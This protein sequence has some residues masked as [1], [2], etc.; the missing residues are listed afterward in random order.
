MLLTLGFSPCPNDTFIFDALVHEKVDTEGLEFEP[1]LEDVEALNL[2]AFRGE[3]AVTKLSYAAFGHVLPKYAMLTAGSALGFGVGPLLVS[4]KNW[5]EKDL[6]EALIAIPGRFTTANFL[7]S[8]AYPFA[9][10]KVEMLF[11]DIEKAVLEGEADAG[12]LIHEN[13][14]T[15][16]KKG[17]QKI[18]D[19]G[20]FWENETRLPIP[21]GGIAVHREVPPTVQKKLGRVLRRSVEFAFSNPEASK[22]YVQTHAQEM[23]ETVQRQHIELYVN[24]FSVDLGAEG[25][26]AV[27]QMLS[28]A[29][30]RKIIP[31][32]DL[33]IFSD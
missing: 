29:R 32:F 16:E 9:K 24:R 28:M 26:S 30:D 19:L 27:E 7:L 10:N 2:R 8:L 22:N 4:K 11:S 18:I 1:I 21:L 12:L 14:F 33:K 3:L 15:F 20:Q 23:D 25:R 17:L 31:D 6:A 13:R 5:A